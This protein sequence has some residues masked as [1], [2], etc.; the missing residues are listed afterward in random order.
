MT[1]TQRSAR[2]TALAY[3]GLAISGIVG[4]LLIRSQL[5]VPDDA[6]RTAAN[7]VAHEGLA[8]LVIA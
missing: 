6:T 8:R 3:L 7:L 1:T 2:L 5:Y 4:F